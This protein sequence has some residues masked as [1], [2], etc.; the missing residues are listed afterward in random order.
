V[1]ITKQTNKQTNIAVSTVSLNGLK[2]RPAF[3]GLESEMSLFYLKL[4]EP[5]F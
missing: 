3:A 5:D 2:I 4:T 1:E